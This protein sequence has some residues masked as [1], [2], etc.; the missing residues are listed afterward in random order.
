[1]FFTGASC[2]LHGRLYDLDFEDGGADAAL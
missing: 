1:V 2:C